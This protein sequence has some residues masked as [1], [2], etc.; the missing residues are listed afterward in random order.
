MGDITKNSYDEANLHTAVIAQRGRDVIDFEWNEMQDILRV[1]LA[2]AMANGTQAVSGTDDLNPGTNDDGFLIVGGGSSNEVTVKA[3]YLFCDGIPLPKTVD[4]T[5]TGFVTPGADRIDTVYIAL[6]ELEVADPAQ[7][8]QLGETT[9]RRKLSYTVSISVTGD[10]G[11]PA[12][13]PTEIWEGGIHYFKIARVTR[14]SGDPLIQ[15]EDVEDLRK[16]LPPSVIAEITRQQGGHVAAL[17]A[18]TI[19]TPDGTLL[20]ESPS[21]FI[22]VD[23]AGSFAGSR[24]FGVTFSRDVL[25]RTPVSVIETT[26]VTGKTAVFL[27]DSLTAVSSSDFLAFSDVGQVTSP[28][29]KYMPLTDS[30]ID[31]FRIGGSGAGSAGETMGGV[32]PSTSIARQLAARVGVSVGDGVNSFGDFNGSTA[33]RDAFKW[34]EAQG[35]G[36]IAIFV[37]PGAYTLASGDIYADGLA[38][39][40]IGT[41][42]AEPATITTSAADSIHIDGGSI[43][44]ENLQIVRGGANQTLF[45]ITNYPNFGFG[46]QKSFFR[47]C[48]FRGRVFLVSPDDETVFEHCLFDMRRDNITSLSC[49]RVGVVD[50]AAGDVETHYRG[51]TIFR[52]CRF[53]N[54]TRAALEF[55]RELGMVGHQIL[56]EFVF[57]RCRFDLSGTTAGA[58]TA[59]QNVGVVDFIGGNSLPMSGDFTSIKALRWLDCEVRANC[60]GDPEWGGAY[61]PVSTLIKLTGYPHGVSTGDTSPFGQ[62][63][64]VWEVEIRGGRWTCPATPTTYNPFSVV[65]CTST[66]VVIEDVYI[67]FDDVTTQ[68]GPEDDVEAFFSGGTF[69]AARWCAFVFSTGTVTLNARGRP[70]EGMLRMSG[71]RTSGGDASTSGDVLI[72]VSGKVDIDGFTIDGPGEAAGG[73]GANPT[74]RVKFIGGNNITGSFAGTHRVRGFTLRTP[75]TVFGSGEAFGIVLIEPN[76]FGVTFE[77]MVITGPVSGATLTGIVF[78]PRSNDDLFEN[79]TFVRCRVHGQGRGIALSTGTVLTG[80]VFSNI[81]FVD[82][83]LT[84]N[85]GVG[86]DLNP[87]AADLV[88]RDL[89]I[90]GCKVNQNTGL[91]VRIR[92]PNWTAWDNV[93]VENNRISN[94]NGALDATQMHVEN[95]AATGAPRFIVTGNRF[96]EGVTLR[97]KLK[98]TR[99]SGAGSALVTNAGFNNVLDPSVYGA[100]TGHSLTDDDL[101]RFVDGDG[102]VLNDGNL[103]TP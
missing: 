68:G 49:V 98:I 78:A 52:D 92:S 30:T 97:G 90:R 63:T 4:S 41:G 60:L 55:S 73:G 34:C 91:G 53:K 83:V 58:N 94:N 84:E 29:T 101:Y 27:L 3:G 85:Q 21:L 26:M 93:I 37:K 7:I 76:V 18:S 31:Y 70:R 62:L 80:V 82:C 2:R 14:R 100:Q 50:Q 33:I 102:M 9:R 57:E 59:T 46:Y 10:V 48:I 69:T 20:D 24:A 45:A 28:G 64:D 89:V 65:F 15:A 8:P 19:E 17:V 72:G 61:S 79:L 71:V 54:N 44:M 96:S 95:T 35:T 22:D 36:E 86:L 5:L 16:R 23:P 47:N 1:Q 42:F 25:A 6:T 67:G 13:T 87:P 11:V 12:N 38:V 66:H 32:T 56:G 39:S 51:K 75:G 40:L 99:R 103:E 77:D 81:E 88:M 74:Q 43:R